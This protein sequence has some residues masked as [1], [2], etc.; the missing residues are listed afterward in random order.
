MG[1]DEFT[2]HLISTA[3]IISQTTLW[4]ALEIF[5]KKK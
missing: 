4:P 2:V 3:W 1:S 5:V